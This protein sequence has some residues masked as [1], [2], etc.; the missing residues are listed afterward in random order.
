MTEHPTR[1]Q[2]L[3]ESERAT[4]LRVVERLGI[5]MAESGIPR[6]PARVF[7]YIL[8]EDA[9]T[10]TAGELAEGLGVSPAAVSGAVRYLVQTGLIT[11]E[12]V[13]GERADHYRIDDQDVWGGML[14]QRGP[15]LRRWAVA[16]D[17]AALE[18]GRESPGACRLDEGRLFFEFMLE[19]QHDV[20]ARWHEYRE[21][22]RAERHAG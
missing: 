11:K 6:M 2:P 10:Y 12:R 9:E 1:P 13:P 20:V 16:F 3:S 5:I 22:R 14:G 21:A 7:A 8:A 18:L 4:L 19:D 17:D 15:M